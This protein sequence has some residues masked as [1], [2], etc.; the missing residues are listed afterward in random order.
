[1]NKYKRNQRLRALQT[2]NEES[3]LDHISICV[4]DILYLDQNV[5][6]PMDA[7]YK[8][9][10]QNH[11]EGTYYGQPFG[12]LGQFLADTILRKF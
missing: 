5:E 10:F 12:E 3:A 6:N 8:P 1:M 7:S 11:R 4:T 2:S 9:L